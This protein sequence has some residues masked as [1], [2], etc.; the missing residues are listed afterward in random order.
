MALLTILDQGLL[1]DGR[2]RQREYSPAHQPRPWLRD[3]R[4]LLLKVER[5][6]V[7]NVEFIAVPNSFVAAC[8]RREGRRRAR[9]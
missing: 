4:Y 6:A 8:Q 2:G 7:I 9:R 1:W 5:L 3:L